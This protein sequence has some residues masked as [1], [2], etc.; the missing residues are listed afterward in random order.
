MN[1]SVSLTDFCTKARV[2]CFSS[3]LATYPGTGYPRS[4]VT[5][6]ASLKRFVKLA[7]QTASVS[8]TI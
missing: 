2:A 4:G 5:F 8:S 1:R 3:T 7:T 6:N